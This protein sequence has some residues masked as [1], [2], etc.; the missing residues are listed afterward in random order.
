MKKTLFAATILLWA[1]AAGAD[2][3]VRSFRQQIPVGSAEGITLEF[4]VGEVTVEAWDSS[5]IDLDVKI[6]CNRRSRRCADAAKALRLVY[7]TS[8]GRV[9][10]EVKNWPKFGGT[11]GMHVVARISVPRDLPL[12]AE[13]GV[14]ELNVEG[15]AGDLTVDLGVG[16]VNITLPKEAIGSVSLDTGIGEANLVAAGRRY[17]SSGFLAHEVRWD[18]GLGR[19]GVSV[20]CGVGEIDVTLR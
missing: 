12:R 16:E 7:N 13:L 4:P 20:N 15:T 6:E 19:A 18:K 2:E 9:R 8:G 5:Q 17:E 1:T 3:I 14:G 10:V 11:K